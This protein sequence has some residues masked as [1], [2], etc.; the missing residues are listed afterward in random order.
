MSRKV[1]LVQSSA[2]RY[3]KLGTRMPLGLLYI[4]TYLKKNGIDARII[5]TRINSG[6]KKELLNELKTADI[7]GTTCMI[8][9]QVTEALKIARFVKAEKPDTMVVFGGVHP[10]IVPEE[11][12]KEDSVDVVVRGEGEKQFLELAKKRGMS[13][14]KGISYKEKG[15]IKHN[16][17][18]TLLKPE[19]IPIPDYS[20]LDMSKYSSITYAGEKGLSIQ[21][22]RGCPYRCGFC[23]NEDFNCGTWR[24]FP[25]DTVLKNIDVLVNDYGAKTIYFVDDNVAANPDRLY[26][27]LKKIKEKPYKINLA[28]QG[29]RIDALEKFTDEVFDLLYESGV[30][31]ID[32]GVETLNERL[33]K[34]VDKHLTPEQ[35]IRVLKSVEKRN[36]NLKLNFIAGLPGQ[37]EKEIKEDIEAAQKLARKHKK[38]YILYNIYMPFPGT[39][40]YDDCLKAGF[41]KPL[42]F[43]EWGIFTGTSW[44]KK[45]SWLPPKTRKYLEDT[46]FLFLFS[47]KN[48]LSKVSNKFARFAISVYQPVAAF[49]LKYKFY[50]FLIERK[51]AELLD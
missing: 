48:I 49:R 20:L 35:I 38:S 9:H 36:F 40:L 28:F 30:R 5:D 4:A 17:V 2:G 3:E 33:L 23:Y 16:P 19:E 42:N 7:V 47:N 45:H 1:L 26:E 41:R 51:L 11:A 22:S 8:G 15:S 25:I 46:S 27:L 18:Q 34:K 12:L 44:M 31:S 14:I 43:E 37:T 24:P 10:S 6:W 21:G 13:E 29:L 32:I 39:K 50:H